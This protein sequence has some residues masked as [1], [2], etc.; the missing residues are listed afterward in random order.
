MLCRFDPRAFRWALTMTHAVEEINNR[1]DLLPNHTLAYSIFDSCA[2]PA[3]A[4]KA[5][6]SVLNGQDVFQSC[7]CS[8]ASNLLGLIGES[9]SSQSIV[10]SRTLSPGA[11]QNTHGKIKK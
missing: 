3:T 10:V 9:G 1:K 7:I 5:V 2:T 4:Q 6:L 8:G 11:F